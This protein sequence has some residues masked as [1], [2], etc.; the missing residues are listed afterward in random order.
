MSLNIVAAWPIAIVG[1]S[2]RR[3][4]QFVSKKARTNRST[5]MTVFGCADAHGLI[6][7]NGIGSDDDGLTPNDWLMQL[8]EQKVFDSRLPTVLESVKDDLELRLR[9]LRANYGS[10]QAKHTFTFGVW[11]GGDSEIYSV[12][13]FEFLGE[14]ED[15]LDGSEIVRVT[16]SLP[17]PNARIRIVGGGTLPPRS[18]IR[19]VCEVIKTKPVDYVVARCIKVVRDVAYRQG[20]AK[21]TVGAA[22]QWAKIGPN[23]EQVWCGLDVVGGRFAQEPPNVINVQAQSPIAGT[24]SIQFGNVGMFKD[25]YAYAVAEDGSKFDIAHYDPITKK[26]VF[27][28]RRC[29]VCN[30]PWPAS[31]RY[32]EVCLYDEHHARGKKQHRK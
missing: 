8:A 26:A 4:T 17:S 16:S 13:N 10:K 29:G 7:Y 27:S 32:C 3:V 15:L 23:R 12:S 25:G 14:S 5:K 24:S 21:G 18:E 30:S 31:H 2:D 22:A 9:K 20:K 19:S 28:E 1:V 11:H 6:V